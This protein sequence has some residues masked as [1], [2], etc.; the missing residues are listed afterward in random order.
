VIQSKAIPEPTMAPVCKTTL[1]CVFSTACL[2]KDGLCHALVPSR[3]V[4]LHPK[5]HSFLFGKAYVSLEVSLLGNCYDKSVY[6]T[7][8]IVIVEE[9]KDAF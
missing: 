2:R 5:T 4:Q 9:L 1:S 7:V 6:E 8:S 3:Q